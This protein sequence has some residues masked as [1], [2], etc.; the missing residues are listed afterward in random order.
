VNAP[1]RPFWDTVLERN[2]APSAPKLTPAQK[3][4]FWSQTVPAETTVQK[5]LDIG[6]EFGFPETETLDHL[7]WLYTWGGSYI[8]V[9]HTQFPE[10]PRTPEE[11]AKEAAVE[12]KSKKKRGKR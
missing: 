6:T 4:Q 1:A 12:V 5:V 8:A 7:R 3:E 11:M 10:Q 2:P 9:D